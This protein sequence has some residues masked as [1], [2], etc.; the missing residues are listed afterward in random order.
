MTK[1][2]IQIRTEKDIIN[3]YGL[4]YAELMDLFGVSK[5]RAFEYLR[6]DGRPS[7]EA[8]REVAKANVGEM[9]GRMANEMLALRG[10][11]IPC[12][13]QTTLFDAG[14]CPKHGEPTVEVI[15]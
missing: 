1:L 7:T 9:E 15:A 13:C 14:P 12:I 6:G 10:A 5:Q 2:Q 8:L 4:G 3:E 11:D